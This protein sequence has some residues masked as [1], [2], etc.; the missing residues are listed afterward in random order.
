M[1]MVNSHEMN[2]R[3]NRIPHEQGTLSGSNTVEPVNMRNRGQDLS[4]PRNEIVPNS[5][6]LR[7]GGNIGWR[8]VTW[9]DQVNPANQRARNGDQNP[10]ITRMTHLGTG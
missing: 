10:D 3:P 5:T 8:C 7:P 9:A 4:T 1:T 2:T 6:Q